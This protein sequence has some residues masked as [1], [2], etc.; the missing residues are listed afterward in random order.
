MD[1]PTDDISRSP[2]QRR[3]VRRPRVLLGGKLVF[4]RSEYTADCTIRDLTETGARVRLSSAVMVHDPIWL[5]N[6]STGIAYKA[7]VAWRSPREFGLTFDQSTDLALVVSGPL[8]RLRR[9][10]LDSMGA[11]AGLRRRP[12]LV[13]AIHPTDGDRPISSEGVGHD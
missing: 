13:A 10:W 4:G 3:G 7:R 6:F 11:G 1:S 8:V 12:L 2:R 5:L 9:I